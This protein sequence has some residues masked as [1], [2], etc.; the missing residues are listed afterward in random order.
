[1]FLLITNT[2]SLFTETFRPWKEIS[3][4]LAEWKKELEF[5]NLCSKKF[6]QWLNSYRYNYQFKSRIHYSNLSF[7]FQKAPCKSSTMYV[8]PYDEIDIVDREEYVRCSI[9]HKN[10]KVSKRFEHHVKCSES[11]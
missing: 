1:M 10:I 4:S 3:S 11:A 8:V 5:L 2:F 9:C 6:P 7:F